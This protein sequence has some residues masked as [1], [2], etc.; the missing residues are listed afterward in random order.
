MRRQ[1]RPDSFRGRL[2]APPGTLGSLCLSLLTLLTLLTL[3]LLPAVAQASEAANHPFLS[4]ISEFFVGEPPPHFEVLEDPC[5]VAVDPHGDVYVADYYHDQIAIFG[6]GGPYLT[7]IAG[8]DPGDGPCAL[9]V[10]AAGRLYVNDYHRDVIR[11]TPSQFPPQFNTTYGERLQIDPGPATGLALDPASGNLL[12]DA[13]TRIVEREPSGTLVRSFGEGLGSGYGVAVS[14]FPAT[15]GEVYVADAATDA[16]EV[17]SPSGALA[18]TIDGA[19]TPQGGFASLVDSALAVDSADGHVFVA[20]NLQSLDFKHPRAALD[21]FNPAGAYRGGLPQFP[22]LLAA[23]PSGLA[24]DSFG[25]VHVTSGNT[26]LADV[27]AYGPTG[28]AHTLTVA[29]SGEGEGTVTSEPAG[30][31]CGTACAA[32]YDAGEEVVLTATPA[33]GSAFAGWSG[34]CSGSSSCTVTMSEGRSVSAEFELSAEP[35]GAGAGGS[36]G[37]SALAAASS[38]SL[39]APA[40]KGKAGKGGRTASA[41]E[42]A[43]K[44]K[45]RVAVSGRLAPQRLPRAG[46]APIAV[47]LGGQISTTDASPL[48]QLR[49]LRIELNRHGR[50]EE[51]GLPVCP[52]RLIEVASTARALA[53]CRGALIGQGDFHANIVLRG[54]PPYPTT[55]KLL[56]FN[57]RE[58]GKPVLLGQIYASKP[59]ATSFVIVFQ[60]HHQTRGEFGTVL[61]ASLLEALG[62]WGYVTA[63]NL[64]LSRRYTYRGKRRSYLSAGCPAPKGFP[65]AIF[66]LA[67]TQFSFA[68]GAKLTSTLTQ[69][70]RARG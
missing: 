70:C 16:I 22:T 37:A 11:L 23:E 15:S 30:I 24:I 52:K 55:G 1:T 3:T 33:P 25:D 34:D 42:V 17:F 6:P 20:D 43:Q 12:I 44:G 66:D 36:A 38:A 10:D 54:Q 9:A 67:R 40:Q 63:I 8:V 49:G 53:A 62:N 28:P 35:L 69:S 5:G 45:L 26:E 21:E 48:P 59:F 68:G 7:R 64:K 4:S 2:K 41:S 57:G 18:G 50:L 65:G 47:S 14:G 58:G 31:A 32:E 56:V 19:G 51:E 60:I 46:L 13:R 39:P 27:F 61:T 29:K